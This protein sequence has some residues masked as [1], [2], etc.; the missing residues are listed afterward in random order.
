MSLSPVHGRPVQLGVME[1]R[2]SP[3]SEENRVSDDM[4]S[5]LRHK[6]VAERL[7]IAF[8]M[9]RHARRMIGKQ[10]ERQH[11]EW[12]AAQVAAETARRLAHGSW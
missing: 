1:R 8:G 2:P 4:A 11:P 12:S 6:T 10:V 5:V 3:P 7:E 9:W